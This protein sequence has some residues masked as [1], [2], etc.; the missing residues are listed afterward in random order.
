M[1]Y[2]TVIKVLKYIGVVLIIVS[3]IEFLF[4]SLLTITRVTIDS[5]T[6]LLRNVIFSSNT[7]QFTGIVLYFFVIISIFM[8]MI[9][10]MYIL[11]VAINKKVQYKGL[12]K[13][14]VVMGMIMVLAA[15]VKMNYLVLL[16][17]NEIETVS[18]GTIRF[19]AA[20]YNQEISPFSLTIFW[21]YFISENCFLMILGVIIATTGIKWTILIKEEQ[22]LNA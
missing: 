14:L 2:N 8:F 6:V 17:K 18:Y 22:P 5:E 3:I 20:I 15:F 4:I 21:F 16:G 11:N 9:L 19:Q 1:E 10:G 7:F 13:L 12:A